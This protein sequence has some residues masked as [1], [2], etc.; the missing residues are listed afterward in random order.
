MPQPQDQHQHPTRVERFLA[1]L[2]A[3]SGGVEPTFTPVESTTPGQPRVT[4]ITYRGLPEPDLLVGVT[5]GLSLAEHADWQHGKPELSVTVRSRD[6]AWSVAAAWIAEDL[7]GRCPFAY[8]DTLDFGQAISDESG[9][10]GFVVFAPL[11]L[12]PGDAQ[13]DV[14]EDHPVFVKGL[15]PT[16]R[17]ER[18]F[19]HAHGLEAFWRLDW[20]PYDVTR[21][22]VA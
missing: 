7:R 22:P 21:P 5:Y 15:Y 6:V 16:Y 2:D 9:M 11:A 13:I 3:V 12:D 4:A 17:S 20:D 14:G 10:D 18:E 8:G 1:H 19:I